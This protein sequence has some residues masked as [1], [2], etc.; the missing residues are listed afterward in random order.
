MS[1][2]VEIIVI[3]SSS[4]GIIILELTCTII[5]PINYSSCLGAN[6]L[7]VSWVEFSSELLEFL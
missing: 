7:G 6:F 3:V 4:A 1:S 2:R 5:W